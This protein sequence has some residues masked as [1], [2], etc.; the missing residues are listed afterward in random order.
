MQ[1]VWTG[2]ISVS[3]VT[4]PIKLYPATEERR[5]RLREVH[6]TDASRVRHR[7]WCQAEDREIPY[8]E[9]GRAWETHDGRLVPLTDEELS[10]LPLPT[11]HVAEVVGFVRAEKIDPLSYGHPYYAAPNGT[12]AQR[13][14]ALLVAALTRTGYIGLARVAIR[15]RER[16]VALRPRDH[17]LVMQTMLWPDE[18]RHP[19]PSMAPKADITERELAL[20]E[21]LVQQLA[22]VELTGQHDEYRHALEQLVAAKLEGTQVAESPEPSGV[23]DLMTALQESV[24]RAEESRKR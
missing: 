17:L 4:V 18:I 22:D 2:T 14:L 12:T 5:V 6:V 3:L 15:S 24:R 16:L 8:A 13:P 10:R 23:V 21:V 9:V 19:E 1:A 7:R 20:A 11:R